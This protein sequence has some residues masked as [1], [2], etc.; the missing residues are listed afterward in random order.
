MA[1]NIVG[2]KVTAK[3]P[4]DGHGRPPAAREEIPPA[5]RAGRHYFS[6]TVAPCSSSLALI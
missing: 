3:A 2:L 1:M 5:P 6:S 4:R